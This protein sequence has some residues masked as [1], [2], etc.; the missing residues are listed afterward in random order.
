[1]S[2]PVDSTL[3]IKGPSDVLERIQ[4]AVEASAVEIGNVNYSN[5]YEVDCDKWKQAFPQW[6]DKDVCLGPLYSRCA[7][8]VTYPNMLLPV[9]ETIEDRRAVRIDDGVL[10]IATETNWNPPYKF[11]Q[12]LAE[13]FPTLEIM[14]SSWQAMENLAERW[15]THGDHTAQ[16]AVGAFQGMDQGYL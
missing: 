13:I 1:M 14:G 3:A 5:K 9:R 12:L 10:C 6:D 2:N 8:R 11:C 7:R 4:N 16:V 15:V